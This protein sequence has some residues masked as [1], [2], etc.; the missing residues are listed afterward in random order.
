MPKKD[1]RSGNQKR[2][3]RKLRDRLI[4]EADTS[5]SSSSSSSERRRRKKMK[6]EQKAAQDPAAMA[7]L[8]VKMLREAAYG[9]QREPSRRPDSGWQ[10][11]MWDPSSETNWGQGQ[12]SSSWERPSSSG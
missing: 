11:H 1:K 4:A 8:V 2:K 12:S 9:R 6:K 5:S 7:E 10:S 3:W